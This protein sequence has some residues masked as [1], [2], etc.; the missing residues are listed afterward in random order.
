MEY[1]IDK[2]INKCKENGDGIYAFFHDHLS[3]DANLALVVKDHEIV[4]PKELKLESENGD[5]DYKAREGWYKGTVEL[6]M[7]SNSSYY[8]SMGF[9]TGI[10]LLKEM[11]PGMK[12][13]YCNTGWFTFPKKWMEI[14][15]DRYYAKRCDELF[16]VVHY[17]HEPQNEDLDYVLDK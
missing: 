5:F 7:D 10:R 11:F 6:L 2:I 16:E 3:M 4:T 17:D 12:A 13:Y 15:D 9:S 1:M 8:G 14:T